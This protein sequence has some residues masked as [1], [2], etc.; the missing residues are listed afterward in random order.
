MIHTCN[1]YCAAGEH[2]DL[3]LT[4]PIPGDREEVRRH[5]DS[6]YAFQYG[7]RVTRIEPAS[8]APGL[9]AFAPEDLHD[10]TPAPR[11]D[12]QRWLVWWS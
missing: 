6:A 4:S 7:A 11:S 1:A 3:V 9:N 8:E 5:L 10:L 2:C 12:S